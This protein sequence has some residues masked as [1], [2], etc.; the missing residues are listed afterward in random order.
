MEKR[1]QLAQ[2]LTDHWTFKT[3]TDKVALLQITFFF[4]SNTLLHKEELHE[5]YGLYFNH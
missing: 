1:H 4:W 2:K 5:M 3:H